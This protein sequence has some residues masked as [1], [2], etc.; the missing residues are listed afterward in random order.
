MRTI[1]KTGL[2]LTLLGALAL[3]ISAEPP[4]GGDSASDTGAAQVLTIDAGSTWLASLDPVS[5]MNGY[6]TF[7]AIAGSFRSSDGTETALITEGR[8]QRPPSEKVHVESTDYDAEALEV[9]VVPQ[10]AVEIPPDLA[11]PGR[12]ALSGMLIRQDVEVDSNRQWFEV[13][14]G[15]V[16]IDQLFEVIVRNPEAAEAS[17][18]GAHDSGTDSESP[19]GTVLLRSVGTGMFLLGL[20]LIGFAIFGSPLLLVSIVAMTVPSLL[21]EKFYPKSERSS[22]QDSSVTG[23][24]AVP[25]SHVVIEP[26]TKVKSPDRYHRIAHL[27]AWLDTGEQAQIE[28][29]TEVTGNKDWVDP[30]DIGYVRVGPVFKTNRFAIEPELRVELPTQNAIGSDLGTIHVNGIICYPKVT[31]LEV[32]NPLDI[33][34]EQGVHRFNE[35]LAVTLAVPTHSSDEDDDPLPFKLLAI[36]AAAGGLLFA[37]GVLRGVKRAIFG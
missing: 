35:S 36:T 32:L 18:D 2:G 29:E 16:T 10:V 30:I 13:V 5:S 9:S 24:Q 34:Y 20:A 14:P 23:H 15:A 27:S 31:T 3:G 8:G 22:S 7:G 25:G 17:E 26:D 21:I 1:T 33:E 12:I 11:G 6:H 28:L 19:V 37:F 4:E